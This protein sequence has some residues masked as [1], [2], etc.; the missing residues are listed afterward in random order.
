M[1]IEQPAWVTLTDYNYG[2]FVTHSSVVYQCIASHTA[3]TFATDLAALKWTA[4]HFIQTSID[5]AIA[6]INAFLNTDFRAATYTSEFKGEGTQSI[7]A[8]VTPVTSVTSIKYYDKSAV[9]PAYVTIFS[10]S[11]DIANSVKVLSSSGEIILFNGYSF[12]EGTIYEVVLVGGAA[13]NEL[14]KGA[15]K[16]IAALYWKKSYQ[17]DG[18]LGLTSRNMAGQ[19]TESAGFNYEQAIQDA[20]KSVEMYK[21]YNV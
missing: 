17:G 8:P 19:G 20:L 14:I 13:A 9:P 2:D 5:Y 18:L 6:R 11:D 16:E 10:G 12:N 4:S 7:Y 21:V 1:K 3:G 15:C